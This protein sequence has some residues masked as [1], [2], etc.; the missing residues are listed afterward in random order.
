MR[1][2]TC[3]SAPRVKGPIIHAVDVPQPSRI[4]NELTVG[5]FLTQDAASLGVP[6]QALRG[7]RFRRL[8]RNVYVH[9]GVEMT[10][11]VRIAAA[12]LILP[13]DIAVSHVTGLQLR[14]VDVGPH[15]PLHVTSP[16]RHQARIHGVIVHR[17]QRVRIERFRGVRVL[18]AG[19]CFVGA[20]TTLS[21]LDLVIAG[22]WLVHLRRARLDDLYAAATGNGHGVQRARRA[23]R[24][25]RQ[26][27]ES[28]RETYLRVMLVT[29]GLPE[30]ECNKD[31][32]DTSQWLG[33][34]DLVYLGFTVIVE[35]DGR[36]HDETR[37]RDADVL[38]V[39]RLRRA[40]W[41]VIVVRSRHLARPREV[42]SRV[43][44]A[45]VDRGYRGPKPRFQQPWIRSFEPLRP[46]G[47]AR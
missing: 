8:H 28:P 35:Y 46:D 45:L 19:A 11:G 10:L 20:A 3:G 6:Y 27:A 43:Y 32:G 7:G 41:T 17:Q 26:G 21:I 33:R 25:V 18:S 44:E 24:Y 1:S 5:P 39:E 30:P 4:P 40:G 34:V 9:T 16:Q 22:D 38:R 42:V 13:A 36:A 31:V 37:R 12:A 15:E 2:G 29:A 14:D 23:L 47:F